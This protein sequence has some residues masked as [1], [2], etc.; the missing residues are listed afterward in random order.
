MYKIRTLIGGCLFIFCSAQGGITQ[1]LA[2]LLGSA[3]VKKEV[4]VYRS[5]NRYLDEHEFEYR[6]RMVTP[7]SLYGPH[8]AQFLSRLQEYDKDY[9][10]LL[11]QP[12]IIYRLDTFL[13]YAHKHKSSSLKKIVEGFRSSLGEHPLPPKTMESTRLL[14]DWP[15]LQRDILGFAYDCMY[16][17]G[18]DVINLELP[19]AGMFKNPQMF[20]VSP[21]LAQELLTDKTGAVIKGQGASP[22]RDVLFNPEGLIWMEANV[23]WKLLNRAMFE[24]PFNPKEFPE[25]YTA[26]F[27]DN[28]HWLAKRWKTHK[29]PFNLHKE[30]TYYTM[31]VMAGGFFNYT[32]TDEQLVA[33]TDAFSLMFDVIH[34]RA[35]SAINIPFVLP[36][37]QNNLFAKELKIYNNAI[38][39]ILD[40]APSVVEFEGRNYPTL[41]GILRNHKDPETGISLT[42]EEIASHVGT[43]FFAAHDTTAN[44]I[45][46]LLYQLFSRPEWLQLIKSEVDL[47]LEDRSKL[48]VP[49]GVLEQYTLFQNEVLRLYP[50]VPL[51]M[52]DSS[53]EIILGGY[54]IPAHTTLG[55][56]IA[57]MGRNPLYHKNPEK[58]NPFRVD[59]TNEDYSPY[60]QSSFTVFSYGPRRCLGQWFALNEARNLVVQLLD[61]GVTLTFD[62]KEDIDLKMACTGMPDR[63]IWTRIDEETKKV[64]S[65]QNPYR[66]RDV[67]VKVVQVRYQDEARTIK[68]FRFA[69]PDGS[70]LPS[71]YHPGDH[72][73]LFLQDGQ[74]STV[75]RHFSISSSPTQSDYWLEITVKKEDQGVMTDLLFHQCCEGDIVQIRY[76]LD[77]GV[78]VSEND[79]VDTPLVLISGGIGITPMIS[80]A[81]YLTDTNWQGH[82]YFIH[83]VRSSSCQSFIEE[84]EKL[85]ELNP[86]FHLFITMTSML[87][88]NRSML[89]RLDTHM[90]RDCAIPN[91][92]TA[93][94]YL[95]GSAAMCTDLDLL[96]KND[97]GVAP[98]NIHTLSFGM[99]DW[100][101]ISG[102]RYTR[103]QVQQHNKRTDGW[104][105]IHGVVYDVTAYLAHHP[106]LD[107]IHDYLGKDATEDFN[108]IPH[109]SYAK[110]LL[111][112]SELIVIKGIVVD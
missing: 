24:G 66:I 59:P 12:D 94:I 68:T 92:A 29:K 45:T 93:R 3:S 10:A 34:S 80:I 7:A 21:D 63:I 47:K 5:I 76:G 4:P 105:I 81:Q 60:T 42:Y 35:T 111:T 103:A 1:W 72:L 70:A 22:L 44:F 23:R 20:V 88:S 91:L 73:Q 106:G 25:R 57:A 71:S 64:V 56:V 38:Y 32:M 27:Q 90:I 85:E 30:I 61:A 96:L 110:K 15:K 108:A 51:I 82:I 19:F 83:S 53:R 86:R 79:D 67:D 97:L 16:R 69:L 54:T 112:E 78:R 89:G 14:G 43:I 102:D 9:V 2:R 109:S 58:F 99:L 37:P 13:D 104:I 55:L 100:Q 62:E 107:I 33:L 95:C 17:H 84:L 77:D 74:G 65:R 48:W 101:K 52:V 46:M 50:S 39:D 49:M 40:H 36:T 11:E 26:L 41:I 6:G 31:R 18:P 28:F 87:R 75:M 98:E 8:A